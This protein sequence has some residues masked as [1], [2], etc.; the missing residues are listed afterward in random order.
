V[1]VTATEGLGVG[2]PPERRIDWIIFPG[3]W[4]A[5]RKRIAA[6]MKPVMRR[7]F[8]KDI[9]SP[10]AQNHHNKVHRFVKLDG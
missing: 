3:N 1:L 9:L 6:I 10:T 5:N 8:L 2:T 7:S 4:H